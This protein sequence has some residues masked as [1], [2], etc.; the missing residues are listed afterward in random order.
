[1]VTAA[2]LVASTLAVTPPVQA[3]EVPSGDRKV[4]QTRPEPARRVPVDRSPLP[5]DGG[6][7]AGPEHA[8][9]PAAGRATLVI[10]DSPTERLRDGGWPS[11]RGVQRV[12]GGLPVTASAIAGRRAPDQTR[13]Q[14]LAEEHSRRLGVSGP[15]VVVEG[16]TGAVE[17]TFS[18]AGIRQLYGAGWGERL[19]L[20][21]LPACAAT[22]PQRSQ[23]QAVEPVAATNDP[24]ARTVSTQVSLTGAEPVVFA[25][26]GEEASEDGDY[27]AT[28]L[29]ASG[30]WTAGSG[31]GGFSYSNPVRLP[32]AEGPLPEVS[33]NYS[34]QAVDGR[35]AG[36]N[37]QASWVGDGWDYAP[38][39]IERTY[40][41]CADDRNAVDGQDPN[42]KDKKTYDHCWSGD[43]PNVTVSLNGTNTSLI[44]DDD[45]GVWRAQ[46]D[47]NWRIQL[48]GNAATTGNATTERWTITTPDGNRYFFAVEA[49]SANSRWTKPVF[50]NHSGEKCHASTFKDSACKQAWRWLLDK[51]VDVH[52]NTVRYYY[53]S[54][55]GHY[56]AA[57]DKDNRQSFHRGGHL[58]RIEY[59]LHADHPSVAATGRVLFTV[60][61]RCLATECHEDGKPVRANWPDVP[62]DKDCATAPCTD[63][64]A[65][66]FFNTKRLTKITTQ[67][68]SGST[69]SNVESWTLA[70]E[71]KAPRTAGSASLWLKE[72]VH[73][74]HVGGTA[75]EP[76]VRFTG[77]ELANRANVL[78][79]APIF[80]RWR[81]QNI[82]TESGADLHV[83]YSETDCD[84]NDLPSSPQSNSR[85][86]YPVYWT[87]DGYTEPQL[88]WFHKYVVTEISEI[89][90]TA[91]QPAIVTRYVYSTGGSSTNVLWAYDDNEFT[92][93][94]HRTY[95]QWRGYSQVVTKVGEPDQ[96]VPLT[97][98]ERFYRGLHDQ[99]LP[100]GGRSSVQGSDSEN[101]TFTDHR[102]LAGFPL[103]KATLDGTTV[104]QAVTTQYWTQ[105]T[106]ARSHAGGTDRA[107]LSGPSV[108]KS[109]KL[110]AP[111]VWARTETRTTYNGDGLATS[112][113]DLGDTSKPG[114]ETC[115]RTTYVTN[116]GEW[117]RQAVSRVETVAKACGD[118]VSRPADVVSDV[119]T[120]HDGSNTHGAAPTKGLVTRQDT[121]DTWTGGPVY[122]TTARTSYDALGRVTS[123]TDARGETTTTAYTPA[124]PGPVTQMVTTNPLGHQTTVTRQPA[125]AEPI[126]LV[127]AN[128]K[129]TDLEHDPLGRLIKVWLPGRPKATRTPN[130]EFSYLVRNNG[131]LAVTSKRLG[132]NGNYL[133][134][135]GL[136]DSLYRQVQTQKD[137]L[138]GQRLISSTGYNDRGLEAY[139]AGPAYITGA[140]D[141][142]VWQ[143]NPGADRART[144]LSY[145]GV[146]RVVSEALWSADSQLWAT[147]TSYG[148]DPDGWRVAVTPPQGGTATI[149]L[150]DV[151]GQTTEL[152]QFHGPTPTGGYDT[153]R[154]TYTPR[155]D[156]STVVGPTGKTWS[157]EYDLRG[158]KVTTTDPDKGT[159]T[160]SYNNA[161][162]VIASTNALDEVVTV[163]H[164]ALGRPSRRF[165]D[166]ELIAQWTYDTLAKGHLSTQ[167]SIVDGF[168]FS[169]QISFYNNAYQIMEE[170]SVIPA[171]PGLE[172]VAGTYTSTST[173]RVDGS[174]ERMKLPRV[175]GLESEI[176]NHTYDD[177]GNVTR[178]V[179]TMSSSGTNTVYVDATTQS[180]FG[181]L[182]QRKLGVEDQPQAYQSYTYD[183]VTRRLT[184]FYFDRDATI[185][186]VAA[187][188]YEYDPAGN[189]LS[190]A[191]RPQD[192]D[193]NPRPAASD[194]QCFQYDHLRR[195]TQAWSQA[196]ATCAATP[197]ASIVGGVAPY[198]MSYAFDR[199]GAR[200]SVTDHRSGL[201][202]N[203]GYA[204]A[205]SPQPYAVRTVTGGGR[206]AQYDWDASGNLTH[207]SVD[208]VDETLE[209]N[210]QGKLTE[211][212]GPAGTTRMVYDVD[213]NRIA[214]LDPNG[215][216][217]VFLGGHEL[218]VV[219]QSTTATR[220][221]SHR[222]DVI[223]SR[224]ASSGTAVQDVIWL[225]AD[226]HGT[227]LWTVNSVTRVDTIKYLDPYGNPRSGGSNGTWPSGQRGFVG[228]IADPNGLSLL[229]ARFYDTFLGAFIS[230]DPL[231]DL[232][233]PQQTQGYSY[234]N[235]NPMTFTDPDGLIPMA[236]GSTQEELQHQKKTGKRLTQNPV[237]NKWTFVAVPKPVYQPS[238]YS[239]YTPRQIANMKGEG[240]VPQPAPA[241]APSPQ[242]GW[243]PFY[244]HSVCGILCVGLTSTPEGVFFEVGGLGWGGYSYTGGATSVPPS[245]MKDNGYA[246]VCGAV[247]LGGCY[248][249]GQ[250]IDGGNWHGGAITAGTGK[251]FFLGMMGSW[252]ITDTNFTNI[253]PEEAFRN[254]MVGGAG[255]GPAS[256]IFTRSAISVFWR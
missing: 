47:A 194:V 155:G 35:M 26:I 236:T 121:L 143:L 79:G 32:P 17:T 28:D 91:D 178:V 229:G 150:S 36:A 117:I 185:P 156:L 106:A 34:S 92:K 44:K 72:I 223:A 111:N 161:G 129:R 231:M 202:S 226:R 147:I 228:G 196:T 245:Y 190:M 65:P 212:T 21:R 104:V 123:A 5:D 186:N 255:G 97:T 157:Y 166:G 37:N 192:D 39:F 42:N 57:G 180:P 55:T 48:Q 113:S 115:T 101:N 198:W 246:Q 120:F 99:P 207:R 114:D 249:T 45:T 135:V 38:G 219:G 4:Q 176:V 64:L 128:N 208:G 78:A 87:P 109:R 251:A 181:E 203:Y 167:V 89:D 43:S 216:A 152:R 224:T 139:R 213:G 242:P 75:T 210:P 220:Y 137:A 74:G 162:D 51:A 136:F 61:D 25:L 209:W 16:G 237:T 158:R 230:V 67:V 13:V 50:G 90:R 112:V 7:W 53:Q 59:G 107:Y 105:Q 80:S 30:S 244:T 191:N 110:L 41:T 84:L 232:A 179:G 174:L 225:G 214:R 108:R 82:R 63:K 140:P 33:L 163:E 62:W 149:T 88:D 138:G 73:A 81:I 60:A 233:D 27:K 131:P 102:A 46:N 10:A 3:A 76:P 221:Y 98:R 6:R 234:A 77:V 127:D 206:S 19:T 18:Y 125:W 168:S 247:L 94:K 254:A 217:T 40:A 164:D 118:P 71:F 56:G 86:C 132:P 31:S 171:M 83:T 182:L 250:R 197:Q 240:G 199:A 205:D 148:G 9:W 69:F 183:D 133:T 235:N 22:T 211:I 134:E 52:G 222:G 116:T 218:T 248:Q 193:D 256:N 172:G 184:G 227:V 145:D 14:V 195:L 103:E 141:T 68:R 144:V 153:T 124:G 173:Y 15:V 66:V 243:S 177:L 126:A 96:G 24:V 142:G 175:G 204:D 201:T 159:T 122:T 200:T 20:K 8:T 187:V 252:K 170:S 54:E 154:Y 93:K 12:A 160:L 169:R 239:R 119:R 1:M 11:G 70:H 95:G 130:L 23:C 100:G 85:L 151:H 241:P 253:E 58:T 189:V 146:G 188:Q 49:A 215:Q 165:A 238:A 29:Q 2:A